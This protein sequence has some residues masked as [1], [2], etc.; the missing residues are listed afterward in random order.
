M[1]KGFHHNW[2]IIVLAILFVLFIAFCT[3]CQKQRRKAEAKSIL[4]EWIGKTIKFPESYECSL[5]GKDTS[6]F[7]C[8]RLMESEYKV[9]I[10]NDST[11]CTECKL[12]LMEWSNLINE[13][14]S[15]PKNHLSFLF[16]LYPKSIDELQLILQR[17]NFP[18]PIFIDN[19]DEINHLNN[20]VKQSKY[21]CF[22][23]DKDNKVLVVGNPVQSTDI[24]KLYK[25]EIGLSAV[26]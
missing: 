22:L 4:D 7:L 3:G 15:I 19:K 26:D 13:L 8:K 12:Q 14:N 11:G 20:F 17:E 16:F 18:Y 21:Q 23:L 24:L 6:L 9:L 1:I 5:S 10:Y 25:K 2:E